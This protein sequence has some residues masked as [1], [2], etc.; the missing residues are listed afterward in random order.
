MNAR[1][2]FLSALLILGFSGCDMIEGAF[3]N[4]SETEGTVDAVG[5]ASIT[6]DATPYAVTVDTEY[7]G[8]TGIEDVQVGDEVEIEYEDGDGGFVALEV[9][10][11]ESD[12]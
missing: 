7:E 8:Y 10:G 1:F 5:P 9:E 12:D 2:A 4:E 3:G 6:V 11:P